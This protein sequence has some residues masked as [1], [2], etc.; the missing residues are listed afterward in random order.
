[1]RTLLAVLL[2]IGLAAVPG[3]AQQFRIATWQVADVLMP[4]STN[5]AAAVEPARIAEIA[6]TLSS[7]DADAI[8][9][10]GITDGQVL[11]RIAESMK[12]KKYSVGI[13]SVF[14]QNGNRGPVVGQPFGILTRR[15][16]MTAKNIE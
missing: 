4:K 8:I 15:D 6:N 12:P 3:R 16:K 13:H 14:R 9:L 7:A 10:Y 11:K 2:V 5:V 1:M